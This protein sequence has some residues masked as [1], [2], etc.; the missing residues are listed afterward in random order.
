M[1][2][3]VFSFDNKE[4]TMKLSDHA[5]DRFKERKIEYSEFIIFGEIFAM[6]D[7]FIKQE[8]KNEEYAI[9][10]EEKELV[11]IFAIDKYNSKM[12]K[13]TVITLLQKSNCF[14]KKG[15]TIYNF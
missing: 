11:I 7:K 10:D 13:A 9:I 6:A 14:I 4:I 15:T 2:N 5:R 3:V 8:S 12:Y 1:R